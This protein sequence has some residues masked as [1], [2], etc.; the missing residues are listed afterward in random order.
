MV[1]RFA[2]KPSGDDASPMTIQLSVSESTSDV[3]SSIDGYYTNWY[4]HI[5]TLD[6]SRQNAK[7]M[8]KVKSYNGRTHKIVV[9]VPRAPSAGTYYWLSP[10]GW[11]ERA[12]GRGQ[13]G[14]GQMASLAYVTEYINSLYRDKGE[15]TL[16]FGAIP[17]DTYQKY[18]FMLDGYKPEFFYWDTVEMF[19]K[20][21]F[22]GL[23]SLFGLGSMKQLAYATVIEVVFGFACAYMQPYESG[24]GFFSWTPNFFKIYFEATLVLTLGLTTMKKAIDLDKS[25]QLDVD[26]GFV[27]NLLMWQ[28]ALPSIAAGL[29]AFLFLVEQGKSWMGVLFGENTG[30]PDM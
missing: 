2:G 27:D 5:G 26:D 17:N 21:V 28:L 8:G 4:V 24:S 1:K 7:I 22:V 11:G 25:D 23:I 19:R 14:E 15:M 30:T 13:Q 18:S 3:P 9:Q 6:G 12:T 29:K 16:T 10:A 20:I